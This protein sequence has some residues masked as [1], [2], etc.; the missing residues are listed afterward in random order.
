MPDV[1]VLIDTG[2]LYHHT[3][4]MCIDIISL[5]QQA[6]NNIKRLCKA[7]EIHKKSAR[8]QHSYVDILY[9]ISVQKVV[10]NKQ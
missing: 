2:I 9:V 3:V 7:S 10:V 8:L 5:S 1:R 6:F 4:Y